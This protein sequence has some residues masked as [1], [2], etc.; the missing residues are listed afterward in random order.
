M[1]SKLKPT[2]QARYHHK[3]ESLEISFVPEGSQKPDCERLKRHQLP[4]GLN[5]LWNRCYEAVRAG[6]VGAWVEL[7][8]AEMIVY[9]VKRI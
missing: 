1:A 8:N 6:G 3:G 7:T 9:G 4:A 5:A 2:A